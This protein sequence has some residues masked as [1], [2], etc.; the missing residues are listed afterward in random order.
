M[1]KVLFLFALV[2]LTAC[3]PEQYK[4][5]DDGLYAE[6]QTNKGNI[7]LELYFEDAPMTVSNFV[8]LA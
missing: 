1:K 2:L 8:S 4:G 5:M 7:L 3:L 6:L